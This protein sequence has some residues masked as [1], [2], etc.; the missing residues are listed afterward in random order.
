MITIRGRTRR[1]QEGQPMTHPGRFIPA[2]LLVAAGCAS[3]GG[4]ADSSPAATPAPMASAPSTVGRPTSTYWVYVGAESADLIH[5][6][7]FGPDGTVVERSVPAG[8]IPTEMEGP[9]GLQ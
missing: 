4:P 9:H 2:A 7:R 6:V 1:T 5:R 8:E 3:S